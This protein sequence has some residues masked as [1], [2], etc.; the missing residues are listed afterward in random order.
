MSSGLAASRPPEGTIRA[1]RMCLADGAWA[2]LRA[3]GRSRCHFRAWYYRSA[4]RRPPAHRTA[5]PVLSWSPGLPR[6]H[7]RTRGELTGPRCLRSSWLSRRAAPYPTQSVSGRGSTWVLWSES[8]RLAASPRDAAG[9]FYRIY[10]AY[11]THD[12]CDGARAKKGKPQV[13]IVRWVCLPDTVD[14]G[15][16]WDFNGVQ[17]QASNGP[18]R[19][20]VECQPTPAPPPPPYGYYREDWTGY[21]TYVPQGPGVGWKSTLKRRQ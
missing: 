13:P 18:L 5:A 10:D 2:A 11:E 1:L 3:S 15:P 6:C 7:R 20:Y 9:F 21:C 19:P 12:A 14:P 17:F 16:R 8:L 4:R